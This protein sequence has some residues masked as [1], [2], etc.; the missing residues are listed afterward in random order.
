M[1]MVHPCPMT[2]PYTELKGENM[3]YPSRIICLLC[4]CFFLTGSMALAKG[5]SLQEIPESARGLDLYSITFS[6]NIDNGHILC[7]SGNCILCTILHGSSSTWLVGTH[8]FW[9]ALPNSGSSSV[10]GMA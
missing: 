6:D 2:N 3:K 4:A 7:H 9:S 10:H 1:G 8:C 5:W